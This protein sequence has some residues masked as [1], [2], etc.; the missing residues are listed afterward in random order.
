VEDRDDVADTVNTAGQTQQQAPATDRATE[1][2]TTTAMT[3]E[4]TDTHTYT[5][6]HTHIHRPTSLHQ[7]LRDRG[8]ICSTYNN[9]VFKY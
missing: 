1:P 2:Q 5:H 7:T 8:R 4:H 3:A 6:I 9:I